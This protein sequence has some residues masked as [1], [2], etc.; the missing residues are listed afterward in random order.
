MVLCAVGATT[1]GGC[2]GGSMHRE[3]GA[4]GAPDSRLASA[5]GVPGQG[6]PSFAR[7]TAR[8]R[9][10]TAAFRWVDSAAAAGYPSTPMPGCISHPTL[11]GM[12]YHLTNE[13][14]LDDRI[15]VERP[16]I[17]VYQRT[18]SGEFALTGVE[19]M[20]PFSAHPRE[21]PAPTVMGQALKP[22]DRGK[23]WYRH[24]WIWLANPAGLFEDWNPKVTCG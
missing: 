20:V 9:S 19:Y 3:H 22:F 12:G 16:E 21:K 6:V 13:K 2:G 7:D 5:A 1:L 11:G 8:L 17:L 4:A 14:L 18:P 24:V 23:F 10:A 15:E